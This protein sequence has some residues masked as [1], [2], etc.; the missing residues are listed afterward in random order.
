ML[1]SRDV[2]LLRED[3][4]VNCLKWQELCRAA[5]LNVLITQTLRDDEYQADL[6][7]QGRTKPGS[8]LT[9]SKVT[10]FHG[11]GLAF[12]F[13][14]NV[15]EHEYDDLAFFKKA[16]DIAKEM[17]FSWGGDW[18][19]FTDRPHLQWDAGG[20]YSGSDVRA[21][22]LP[23]DMEEYMTEADVIKI[24]EKHEAAKAKKSVSSWAKAA[25]A[26]AKKK[27]VFD[28]TAPQGAATREQLAVILDRLGLL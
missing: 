25:W 26:K 4:R 13:C 14:K 17:G 7:A 18:T 24:I 27:G 23:P 28:G 6:Y 12:D 19:S 16:A 21:G 8:I 2:S 15:K 20:K 22:R 9:N 10:T 1:N 3:V 11:V 5:G